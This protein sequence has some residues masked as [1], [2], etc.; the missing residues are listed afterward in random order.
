[1]RGGP[2]PPQT[3]LKRAYDIAGV[4]SCILVLNFMAAPFMLLTLHD[5][6][7]AWSRLGWYGLWMVFGALAFFFGGGSRWLK[8]MQARRVMKVPGEAKILASS[9]TLTPGIQTLPPVDELMQEMEKTG[10][11]RHL[12]G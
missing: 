7:L 5:S 8:S 4:V 1:M 10:L 3:S 2:P 11:M 6:F 12:S 9:G